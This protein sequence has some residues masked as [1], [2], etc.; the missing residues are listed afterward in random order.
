MEQVDAPDISKGLPPHVT[1]EV[2]EAALA[3]IPRLPEYFS[4]VSNTAELYRTIPGPVFDETMRIVNYNS[5]YVVRDLVVA[6]GVP[7]D[8]HVLDFGCGTGMMGRLLGQA[9]FTDITGI[10]AC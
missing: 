7:T 8:S 1:K 3:L 10:D 2:H 5:P 6:L 9:G 4:S